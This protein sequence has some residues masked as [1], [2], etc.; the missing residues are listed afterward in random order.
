[1]TTAEPSE[2]NISIARLAL[3]AVQLGVVVALIA[4]LMTLGSRIPSMSADVGTGSIT[5]VRSFTPS[6]TTT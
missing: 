6:G 3:L 1:L 4:Q 2:R 5:N